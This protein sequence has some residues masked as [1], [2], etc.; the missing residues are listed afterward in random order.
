ME[1]VLNISAQNNVESIKMLR[2]S[3]RNCGTKESITAICPLGGTMVFIKCRCQAS[4]GQREGDRFTD[5]KQTCPP[6]AGQPGETGRL[7]KV[8]RRPLPR[9]S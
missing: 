3:N 9:V 7:H 8:P 2:K 4:G 1:L 5:S 6:E